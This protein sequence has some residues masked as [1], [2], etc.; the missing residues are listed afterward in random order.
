[1]VN[2]L[3]IEDDE[4]IKKLYNTV[5][6]QKG[7]NTF[8][9][10][11]GLNAFDILEDTH[12]D[13]IICDVMMPNMDGFE[14]TKELRAIK[15]NMPILMITAKETFKDKEKGFSLGVDDYMV[16]P[17]DLNEMIWRIEALLRRSQIS[18]ENVVTIGNTMFNSETLEVVT[19]N[20]SIELPQ[21]EFN[22]LFLLISYPN[23]VYTR[24]QLMEKIWGIDN[25]S[26]YHTL[27]VHISRLRNKF[28]N[29]NDFEITTVRG[30]GYKAV[31]KNEKT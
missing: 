29:N 4:Q 28:K 10:S 18:N 20:V 5:I 19:D 24:L 27:E 26:D 16:K 15:Y 2:I 6:T 11:D 7:Y 25:D 1:M 17:I 23:K 30:L 31:K 14:F 22:L 8:L 9:A 21:K 12:I 13:L 3:I